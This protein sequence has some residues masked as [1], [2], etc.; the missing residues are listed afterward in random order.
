MA[1]CGLCGGEMTEGV[2]C[3]P[4]PLVLHGQPY[5]P[6]RWGAER[7]WRRFAGPCDDCA[8]P[9]SGVHHHGC[10]REEC[11]RCHRQF[12]SCSCGDE[13]DQWEE[14][15]RSGHLGDRTGDGRWSPLP[16]A[17]VP[18]ARAPGGRSRAVRRRRPR[19]HA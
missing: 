8:T 12:L 4:A 7:L 1:V 15:D 3:T 11:P 14:D 6:V 17:G 19:R 18:C 2:S 9:P 5:E 16:G 13:D 10:D